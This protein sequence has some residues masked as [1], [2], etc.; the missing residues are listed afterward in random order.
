MTLATLKMAMAALADP[1]SN[2]T[3]VARR[4]GITRTTL[5]TYVNSDGSVKEVGQRLLEGAQ[6]KSRHSPRKSAQSLVASL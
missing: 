6:T 2:A 3:E 4:L 1:R 5:Y